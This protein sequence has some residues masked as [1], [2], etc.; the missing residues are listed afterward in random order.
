M[1]VKIHAPNKL[2]GSSN[3]GSSSTLLNYLEKE[4]K[5]K[6]DD[7]KE[8]FF[9]HSSDNISA[10]KAEEMIDGNNKNIG[11]NE[12]KY[13]MLTVN[14]S[15]SEQ[16][17]LIE[18]I[19]GKKVDTL[20]Q[21][22][23]NEK[24]KVFFEVKRYA[25]ELMGE[26][27]RNFERENVRSEKDLV[28]V[29]KIEESRSYKYFSPEVKHNDNILRQQGRLIL[30]RQK[31]VGSEVLKIDKELKSLDAKLMKTESGK[32]IGKGVKKE[33]LNLH[34]HVVVS[35]NNVLQNTKIS[36][37]S[38]SRGGE[39]MLNG[40]MV[41][42]GFN[43]E[44]FKVS[45]AELFKKMYDYK[46]TSNEYYLNTSKGNQKQ[47]LLLNS[48]KSHLDITRNIKG[49][50]KGVAGELLT[51]NMLSNERVVVTNSVQTAKNIAMLVTNPKSAVVSTLKQIVSKLIT[52][53]REI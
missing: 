50:I 44:K 31:A 24:L 46:F 13:Y 11:K 1:F 18:K 40:K 39:Q 47:S 52:N 41:R 36:P 37:L 30:A 48:V 6:E 14:P 29:A 28:Y 4:N 32:V 22:T 10:E 20:S 19:T 17:H 5:G 3:K 26:Y 53:A 38:N 35:R 49:S 34:V 42:Q 9:N 16:Q 15:H 12:A 25:N 45:S 2:A 7:F 27:A 21:L 43:H 23:E 33:G 51:S 8:Q